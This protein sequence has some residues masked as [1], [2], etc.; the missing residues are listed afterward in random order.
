MSI[1]KKIL[2]EYFNINEELLK[3]KKVR[4]FPSSK[5]PEQNIKHI[6]LSCLTTIKSFREKLL[7]DLVKPITN[8]TA[9]LEAYTEVSCENKDR[10]DALLVL[11]TGKNNPTIT[12][13]AII[14]TKLGCSLEEEQVKRYY[15]FVKNSKINSF[16]TISNDPTSSPRNLPFNLR[17]S[18]NI[19]CFHFSWIDIKK[20]CLL[21]LNDKNTILSPVEKIIIEEF[22]RYLNDD[23]VKIKDFVVGKA[24]KENSLMLFDSSIKKKDRKVIENISSDWIQEEADLCFHIFERTNTELCIKNANKDKKERLENI[25]EHLTKTNKLQTTFR[26]VH[27][28]DINLIIDFSSRT[29]NISI[30]IFPLENVGHVAQVSSL[31]NKFKQSGFE[32]EIFLTIDYGRNY[33]KQKTIKEL[34]EEKAHSGRSYSIVDKD[35]PIKSFN[36]SMKIDFERTSDF[37]SANKFDTTIEDRAVL[38]FIHFFQAIY[39]K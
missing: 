28:N 34:Q 11:T 32:H 2:C 36:I 10:P 12:W 33:V 3:N 39:T 29:G 8:Q 4:M 7:G 25:I 18:N 27:K 35:K 6:F 21:I 17:K 22:L 19:D 5:Q 38:F 24:W 37:H 1:D 9:N 31:L 14:E 26:D 20:V 30:N 16:I 23:N 13:T 15:D